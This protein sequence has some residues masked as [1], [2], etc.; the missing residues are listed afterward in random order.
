MI[1]DFET[2]SLL[3]RLSIHKVSIQSLSFSFNDRFLVSL[4]GVEDNY[5]IVWDVETGKALSG[6]TAGTDVVNQV[7]FFNNSDDQIVTCQNYGIRVWK[8]DYQNKKVIIF[9]ENKVK[10]DRRSIR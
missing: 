2:G 10:T 4:G 3:H 1:W 7:K 6:N 8:I 5:L 9:F